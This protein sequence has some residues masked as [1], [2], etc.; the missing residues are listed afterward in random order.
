ML[1]KKQKEL[2]DYITVVNKKFGISPSYDE[3]KDKLKLKSKSGIHRIISALEE[4]GFIRKLAN[5]ARAIEIIQ[6][7]KNVSPTNEAINKIIEIPLYGKIAAGTPIEAISNASSYIPTPTNMVNKGE[8]YALE[9]SGESMIG[10]GIN[11]KDIA[12]IKRTTIANNGQIVV[13]LID[14]TEATL[15]KFK[16]TSSKIVLIPS[17][18]LYQAQSYDL[19]RVQIQG[20]LVGL[21]RKY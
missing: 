6:N 7:N 21:M 10:S 18:D 8:H 9:I 3:M 17:N 16:K 14:K 15:K 12:I 1:T 13:A 4:R 11:D 5:K 19:P 2:L 20:I